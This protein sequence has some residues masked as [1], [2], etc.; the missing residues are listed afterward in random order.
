[1]SFPEWKEL[2]NALAP[3]NISEYGLKESDYPMI[4]ADTPTFLRQP[5]ARRPED[6]KGADFA[7]VGSPYATGDYFGVSRKVWAAAANRVRKVSIMYSG[8]L[9]E[10]DLDVLEHF[11]IVDFG[12]A[13]AE[14][15]ELTPENI[16]EAQR[17]VETK[18]GQVLDAGVIPIVIGQNSPCASYAVAKAIAERTRGN[19]GVVSLDEHWDLG[20]YR[21]TTLDDTTRDPRIAGHGNWKS[22]LYE[23]HKNV[24]PRNLVEIG[25]RGMLESRKLVRGFLEKGA[26]FY[27]MWK[28]REIG[29][30]QLCS[31]LRYAYDG[32]DAVWVH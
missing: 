32:T 28:V 21:S 27:P 29:I 17:A 5:H 6:L 7:I 1:M 2:K 18:V 19:V 11:K 13:E 26:H 30:E 9:Q 22:K 24:H 14:V 16:L 31:E 4:N 3:G 20:Y 15:E 23:W 8:Y 10:F 12:D 25:E